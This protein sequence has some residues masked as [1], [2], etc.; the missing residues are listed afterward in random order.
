MHIATS[1]VNAS[2]SPR[3]PH[4][5]VDENEEL[6]K[7]LPAPTIAIQYWTTDLYLFD[8]LQT[9][10]DAG[11]KRRPS[12]NSLYDVFSTIRDD[13]AGHVATMAQ[14]QDPAVLM[15]SPS[16]EAAVAA[17]AVAATLAEL[18]ITNLPGSEARVWLHGAAAPWFF[19]VWTRG[20]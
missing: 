3:L 13:E 10:P 12:I 19:G 11:P 16:I 17:T 8:E 20:G 5:F 14:C 18:L 1:V 4:Q 6:L 2:H 9:G 15:R 7:S